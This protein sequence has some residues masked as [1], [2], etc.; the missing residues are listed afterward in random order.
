M[1]MDSRFGNNNLLIRHLHRHSQMS[2][3]FR[4]VEPGRAGGI[5]GRGSS[6]ALPAGGIVPARLVIT[7]PDMPFGAAIPVEPVPAPQEELQQQASEVIET[8]PVPEAV[9]LPVEAATAQEDPAWQ[10]LGSIYQSQHEQKREQLG[11]SMTTPT[12]PGVA[13]LVRRQA[14]GLQ[15]ST[16]PQLQRAPATQPAAQPSATRT[17][18]QPAG[19]QRTAP[20]AAEAV[21]PPLPQ[22]EQNGS[23]KTTDAEWKRLELISRLHEEKEQR[24]REEAIQRAQTAPEAPPALQ[25]TQKKPDSGVG[26]P[27]GPKIIEVEPPSRVAPKTAETVAPLPAESMAVEAQPPIQP[28]PASLR[29]STNRDVSMPYQEEPPSLDKESGKSLGPMSRQ[30]VVQTAKDEYR[31]TDGTHEELAAAAP[32][33][34]VKSAAMPST[35]S[36][37]ETSSTETSPAPSQPSLVQQAWRQLQSIFRKRPEEDSQVEPSD[38]MEKETPDLHDLSGQPVISREPI[39]APDQTLM[40]GENVSPGS[41]S[42]KL[43][44][45]KTLTTELAA[46]DKAIADE[47]QSEPAPVQREYIPVVTPTNPSGETNRPVQPVTPPESEAVIVSGPAAGE[48]R[49]E[50]QPFEKASQA[51]DYGLIETAQRKTSREGE[52]T[53]E[54]IGSKAPQAAW[55]PMAVPDQHLPL[56]EEP[57]YDQEASEEVFETGMDEFQPQS[58]PLE[59]AWPVERLQQPTQK[60]IQRAEVSPAETYNPPVELP[61][62]EAAQIHRLMQDVKPGQPSDS[63]L[64]MITPLKPRP[65]MSVTEQAEEPVEAQAGEENISRETQ[66]IQTSPSPSTG[67]VPPGLSPELAHL[68]GMLDEMQ[69]GQGASEEKGEPQGTPEPS[70]EDRSTL[71]L[72]GVLPGSPAGRPEKDEIDQQIRAAEAP[73][74]TAHVETPLVQRQETPAAGTISSADSSQPV[75]QPAAET[76]EPAE[77]SAGVDVDQLARQVYAEVKRKLALE[78]ERMR[79]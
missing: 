23:S 42:E 39:A 25:K 33:P 19:L 74:R 3:L 50:R 6:T 2:V 55:Q 63:M 49:P 13:P 57:A 9:P 76:S 69:S 30:T 45:Q 75:S 20:K 41:G 38:R 11:V 26:I 24:E 28:Q 27:K 58:L 61:A 53:T 5:S 71:E 32:S 22:A 12:P 67:Q 77:S 21:N 15:M 37:A 16:S 31:Q 79:R 4:S 72:P 60:F 70:W 64:E 73:A 7:R 65:V 1:S 54:A 62:E 44:R 59:E 43:E 40:S 78:W 56:S 14:A 36:E 46:E 48:T 34:V 10:R 35:M 18:A 66:R 52:G 17:S 29:P 51:G 8:A 47:T 68:W